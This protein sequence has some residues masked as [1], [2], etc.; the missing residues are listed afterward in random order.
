MNGYM[1]Y[2]DTW[3]GAVSSEIRHFSIILKSVSMQHI[4]TEYDHLLGNS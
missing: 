3:T 2:V 4:V 1:G